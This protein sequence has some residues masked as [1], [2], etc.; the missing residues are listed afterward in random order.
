MGMTFPMDKLVVIPPDAWIDMGSGWTHTT[1]SDT[2]VD[3]DLRQ[4]CPGSSLFWEG[5]LPLDVGGISGQTAFKNGVLATRLSLKG[6][7]QSL[8]ILGGIPEGADVQTYDIWV[9]QAGGWLVAL[10]FD[11]TV[12][13]EP[14]GI[15]IDVTNPN[16][17]TISVNPPM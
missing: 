16:D 11:A 5:F 6:V 10:K 4:L 3:S 2:T 1:P 12:D 14:L 7:V 15:Q 13:G 8:P 17:P 9:A